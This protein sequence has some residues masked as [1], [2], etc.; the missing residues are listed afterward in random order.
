MIGVLLLFSS[1][2]F[3]LLQHFAVTRMLEFH[4]LHCHCNVTISMWSVQQSHNTACKHL[5]PSLLT[6]LWTSRK[7]LLG[8]VML[9]MC[10]ITSVFVLLCCGDFL[11]SRNCTWHRSSCQMLNT[12]G[13]STLTRPLRRSGETLA[14]HCH[15]QMWRYFIFS[16]GASVFFSGS[17]CSTTTGCLGCSCTSSSSWI[18]VWHSLRSLLSFLCPH[19]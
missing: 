12:T 13:T 8:R 18:W 7:H 15:D 2:R 5:I 10:I 9:L 19:G 4:E 1:S 3:L 17:I 14:C 6:A 11:S 16:A